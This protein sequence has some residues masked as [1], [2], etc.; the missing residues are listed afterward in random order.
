MSEGSYTPL[1]KDPTRSME[2]RL[3][4]LLKDLERKGE[5]PNKTRRR[6]NR[7]NSTPPQIYG[8]PK[9]H[10][11]RVSLRPVVSTIGSF[12][13]PLAK[14]LAR[15]LSPLVGKT[16]SFVKNSAHFV[17]KISDLELRY[18]DLMV[19]FGVKSLFT[20]TPVDEAM[21]VV[22]RR[23]RSDDDLED[24]TTLSRQTVCQLTE[25]CLTSTSSSRGI[26]MNKHQVWPWDTL[27]CDS[28]HVHEAF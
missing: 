16:E 20:Q 26:R 5:L 19:S 18:S 4:E 10:K 15:I 22:V 24:R 13:Y 2:Q 3:N 28:Q 9:V 27:T 8:L 7:N 14:K 12:A 23:S 25:L 11:D 1:K 21:E 17:E 6:L